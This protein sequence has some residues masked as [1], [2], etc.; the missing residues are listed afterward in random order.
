MP[1]FDSGTVTEYPLQKVI[2]RLKN[3]LLINTNITS[4]F[5]DFFT[6]S[7]RQY[8]YR[9]EKGAGEKRPQYL[10]DNIEPFIKFPE[11]PEIANYLKFIIAVSWALDKIC[12]RFKDKE[13]LEVLISE[14]K[15]QY[16][17][18]KSMLSSMYARIDQQKM[19]LKEWH[20][21]IDFLSFK[22]FS[23]AE[24]FS[25]FMHKINPSEIS[26]YARKLYSNETAIK[27]CCEL[28][29][30]A[31]VYFFEWILT[32]HNNIIVPDSLSALFS[33]EEK[34]LNK[35]SSETNLEEIETE[36]SAFS[37]KHD[38]WLKKLPRI[39]FELRSDIAHYRQDKT[40]AKDLILEAFEHGKYSA[41]AGLKRIIQRALELCVLCGDRKSF[42]N[43]YKWGVF[44][45]Y[46]VK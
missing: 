27:E 32:N 24:K 30:D 37:L 35:L 22:L 15:R 42:N 14:F 46:I 11:Y 10:F 2:T 17:L 26:D 8:L 6:E 43:V 31:V 25:C 4:V 23:D 9:L 18:Q 5:G 12:R 19:S 45:G 44:S 33:D 1:E 29:G 28:Y 13:N 16:S 20:E 38:R 41:G 36:I 39:L 40:Q 34:L 3:M 21:A 7:V